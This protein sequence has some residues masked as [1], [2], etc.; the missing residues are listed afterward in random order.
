[1]SWNGGGAQLPLSEGQSRGLYRRPDQVVMFMNPQGAWHWQGPWLVNDEGQQLL[2]NYGS[3]RTLD[4]QAER[5][6]ELWLVARG[7]IVGAV[8]GR[9]GP[10]LAAGQSRCLFKFGPGHQRLDVWLPVNSFA[11]YSLIFR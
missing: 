1:M 7:G 6:G 8:D 9:P 2:G 10:M 11:P 4:F 3:C 5:A